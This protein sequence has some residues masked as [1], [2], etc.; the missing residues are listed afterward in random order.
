LSS[1]NNELAFSEG[2]PQAD[3]AANKSWKQLPLQQQKGME[4]LAAQFRE[5]MSQIQKVSAEP[6]LKKPAPRMVLN[7][8]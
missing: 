4:V 3:P 6:E 1:G 7:A 2:I 5:Q 8:Q